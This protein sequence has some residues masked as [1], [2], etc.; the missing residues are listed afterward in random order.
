M[1]GGF[2]RCAALDGLALGAAPGKRVATFQPLIA[3]RRRRVTSFAALE[4]RRLM[5]NVAP[6]PAGEVERR[7]LQATVAPLPAERFRTFACAIKEVIVLRCIPVS[8]AAARKLGYFKPSITTGW[9]KERRTAVALSMR[10]PKAALADKAVIVLR[11]IPVL[12]AAARKL[13]YFTPFITTGWPIARRT[14]AAHLG[15]RRKV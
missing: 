9:P 1:V 13:G 4:R 5:E 15:L 10:S 3:R 14:A 6:L 11:C 8:A 7:R 12:A 2:A